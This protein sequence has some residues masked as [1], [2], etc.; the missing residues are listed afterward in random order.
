MKT[1]S[2]ILTMMM[3]NVSIVN[4]LT[5]QEKDNFD[6][7]QLAFLELINEFRIRRGR[8]ALQLDIELSKAAKRHSDD[9]VKHDRLDHKGSDGSRFFD[10]IKD[11]NY[12]YKGGNE[13]IAYNWEGSA[14]RFFDQWRNSRGHRKNMLSKNITHLGFWISKAPDGKYYGT[15]VGG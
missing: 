7:E 5:A 1:V 3:F 13:N 6:R 8:T 2:L 12:N 15:M 11:T 14:Q 4:E 10:R 9:M